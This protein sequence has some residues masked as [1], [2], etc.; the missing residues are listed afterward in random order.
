M[1]TP[2]TRAPGNLTVSR[3]ELLVDGSDADF[4]RLILDL[5]SV[6]SRMT[7]MRELIGRMYGIT[8]VQYSFLMTIFNLHRDG[9]VAPSALAARLHVRPTFVTAEAKKLEKRGL[10]AKRAN[11]RDRRGIFLQLTPAGEKLARE[12]IPMIRALNDETFRDLSNTDYQRLRRIMSDLVAS[13]DDAGALL[14]RLHRASKR[15][16]PNQKFT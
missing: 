1:K 11:P 10:L 9:G 5:F 3:E 2:K 8:G 12:M 6:F 7:E 13:L 14:R 15:Q 16:R 4:R